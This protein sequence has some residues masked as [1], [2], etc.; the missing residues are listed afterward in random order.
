MRID[1][2]WDNASKTT[3]RCSFN[4]EWTWNDVFAMN[5]EIIQMM[6]SVSHAVCVIIVMKVN[7]FP[8]SGT[9]T[10]TKHLFIQDHTNYADHV[11]FVGDNGLIKTFEG[12]IRRAYAQ[13]MNPIRSDYVASLPD[14][15]QL[16]QVQDL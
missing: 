15:Y 16:L 9:L 6:E 1:I 12:I 10:Y 8:Q 13:A 2:C 7:K 5:E 4:P 11:I 3:I 14:A